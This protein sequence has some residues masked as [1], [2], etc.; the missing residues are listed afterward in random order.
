MNRRRSHATVGAAAM[1]VGE[2]A[3]PHQV[4]AGLV[5]TTTAL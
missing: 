2:L 5:G 3:S 1:V 4:Q